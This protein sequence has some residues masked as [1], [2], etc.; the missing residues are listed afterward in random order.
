M[1]WKAWRPQTA[2][3]NSPIEFHLL[4]YAYRDLK[5]QP[6]ARLQVHGAYT[7]EDLPRLLAELQRPGTVPAQWPETWPPSGASP[8]GRLAGSGDLT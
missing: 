5:V 7:E 2:Q 8:A 6:S 1:C 3:S 4:G